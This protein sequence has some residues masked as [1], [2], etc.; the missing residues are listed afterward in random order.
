[1]QSVRILGARAGQALPFL[2]SEVGACRKA[3]LRVL[4]LV[5][6]QY[7]LQAE[8]ELVDGLKLPGLMDID[9]L[10]PR[11]LMRRVRERG[12]RDPLSPLDS[13]GR[14]MAL[15]QALALCRE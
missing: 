5:P 9:V 14:A 12:G 11:R 6:E 3:G 13:R 4:L 7:T 10:S 15:S 1:M 8:R 2:I